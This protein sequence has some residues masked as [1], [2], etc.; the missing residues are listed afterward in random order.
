MNHIP[1]E[2]AFRHLS[3]GIRHVMPSTDRR[4][5]LKANDIDVSDRLTGGCVLIDVARPAASQA[6][7]Y[8]SGLSK[9]EV[10]ISQ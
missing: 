7:K 1:N 3:N 2:S 5:E 8:G 10:T 4:L 6:V 9:R